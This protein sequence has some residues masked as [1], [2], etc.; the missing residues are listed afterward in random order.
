[1]G[2]TVPNRRRENPD[3]RPGGERRPRHDRI[4]EQRRSSLVP[5][6]VVAGSRCGRGTSQIR[7]KAWGLDWGG[8][9]RREGDA[10]LK[11]RGQNRNIKGWWR[12]C[13]KAL[14]AALRGLKAQQVRSPGQRPGCHVPQTLRPVRAKVKA[15]R[16]PILLPLQGVGV[17][18][19]IPRALPWAVNWRPFQGAPF[20]ALF[21]SHVGYDTA[22]QKAQE[23]KVSP[24]VS[25]ANYFL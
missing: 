3:S 16:S 19:L 22:P 17:Y 25:C 11:D 15:N 6:A 4:W 8:M 9:G 21:V 23:T 20:R 13:R 2:S 1:M 18:T 24:S 12:L 5:D 7:Q 14:S 10:D